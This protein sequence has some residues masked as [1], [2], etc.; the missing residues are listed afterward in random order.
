MLRV[1]SK[2][3]ENN[4]LNIRLE[5]KC[6]GMHIRLIQIQFNCFIFDETRELYKGKG[7]GNGKYKAYG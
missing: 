3:R 7:K 5:P 2:Y 1:V 4:R 6:A